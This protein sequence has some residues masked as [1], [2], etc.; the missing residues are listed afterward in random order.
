M[1]GIDSGQHIDQTV[2]K[3]NNA[4]LV[5]FFCTRC[6]STHFPYENKMNGRIL[7]ADEAFL[8]KVKHL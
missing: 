4:D 5:F 7:L 8:L 2:A 3:F 6:T 1:A